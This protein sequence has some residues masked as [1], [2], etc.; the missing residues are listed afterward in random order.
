MDLPFSL[1]EGKNTRCISYLHLM[2]DSIDCCLKYGMNPESGILHISFSIHS[3][4][5]SK[6]NRGLLHNWPQILFRLV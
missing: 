4:R 3:F 2:N 1:P 5:E 6:T